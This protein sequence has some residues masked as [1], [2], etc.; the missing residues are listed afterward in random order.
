MK[1]FLW[2]CAALLLGAMCWT[3]HAAT[4]TGQLAQDSNHIGIQISPTAQL[5]DNTA[6]AKTITNLA[7]TSNVVTLT[8]S[9]P[10]SYIVGQRVVVAALTGPTLFADC[11]GTFVITVVGSSTTFSY[12]FTHANITTG[13]ATGTT[14]A[15]Y[16]SPVPTGTT[17]ITLVFP[18]KAYALVIIPT[19]ATDATWSYTTS[20]GIG[21]L[22]PLFQ[23]VG[24]QIPGV[25]GDVV[26]IQRT[27][28]TPLAFLFAC[29]K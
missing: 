25:E 20:G 11:N 12:A 28:T 26:Y 1:F 23:N 29:G 22:F 16:L 9:A 18:A 14:T 8:T 21:G 6:N 24:N 4:I 13:A 15:Y 7:L 27:T 2:Y 19:A 10:H 17:Q 3:G 5:W